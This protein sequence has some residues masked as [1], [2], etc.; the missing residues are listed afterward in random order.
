MPTQCAL[1]LDNLAPIP[2]SF[3]VERICRLPTERMN[4]VCAALSIATGC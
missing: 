2:R 4:Q 1:R 3:F